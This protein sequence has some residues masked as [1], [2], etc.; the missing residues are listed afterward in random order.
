MYISDKKEKLL[1]YWLIPLAGRPPAASALAAARAFASASWMTPWMICCSSGFRI[2]VSVSYSCGC[3]CWRS[4]GVVSTTLHLL[5]EKEKLTHQD[6]FE[7]TIRLNLVERGLQEAL[8]IQLVVIIIVSE[9]A[10]L[11]SLFDYISKRRHGRME[12]KQTSWLRNSRYAALSSA[13]SPSRPPSTS[14]PS[15]HSTSPQSL[16]SSNSSASS[17]RVKSDS[18][19]ASSRS[20]GWN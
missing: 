7:Q 13:T 14:S 9:R 16:S 10:K 3:S 17:S 18:W 19:V 12:E 6:M 11:L 2:F 4:T 20:V 5:E 1:P 8:L 15:V